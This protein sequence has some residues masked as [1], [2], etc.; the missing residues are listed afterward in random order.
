[1]F[2]RLQAE[3]KQIIRGVVELV[4]FM[5]GAI[6]YHDMMLMTYVEREIVKDF[7]ESRLE[8]QKKSLNPVY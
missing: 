2:S 4:Y 3:S 5:R 8:A 1:M 6:Q 7:I